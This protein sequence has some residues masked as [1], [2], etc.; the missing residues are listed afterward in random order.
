MRVVKSTK[1]VL[2]KW[3]RTLEAVHKFVLDAKT[4]FIYDLKKY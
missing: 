4:S 3:K 1:T 2:G